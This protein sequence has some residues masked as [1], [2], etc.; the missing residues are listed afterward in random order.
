MQAVFAASDR[1]YPDKIRLNRIKALNGLLSDAP[2]PK[3]FLD[4]PRC[5]VQ[6]E[7]G[8]GFRLFHRA[9]AG[10]RPP[11]APGRAG[12]A[13]RGGRP[14]PARGAARR[15]ATGPTSP[16][17]PATERRAALARWLTS[18]DNPLVARV[19]VNRVWGWHF[20]RGI[21]AHAQR[22]RRP[23]RAA[24]ASRAARLAGRAT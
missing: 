20:G 12:Q 17:L 24:D 9:R 8:S 7:D 1:P 15:A 11:A 5:T 16:A 3:E 6:T 2:V 22:L 4:D 23:G 10:G 19:L 14:G 21:V 18:P 13:P